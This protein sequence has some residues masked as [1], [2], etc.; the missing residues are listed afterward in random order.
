MVKLLAT[1][2]W[3]LDMKAGRLSEEGK[4]ALYQARLDA[5]SALL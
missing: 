2:D 5:L 4:E 3:Q 1:A